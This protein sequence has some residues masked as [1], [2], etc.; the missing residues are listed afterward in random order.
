MHLKKIE[1]K[2]FKSF[3][4]RTAISPVA[5]ITCVVGPNGSGKS[6]I[7]DAVR[8]VLGEQ[9]A[10]IL[11]G[12][13]MEDI[14]FSGTGKRGSLGFAE[15]KL[16]ID[17][18]GGSLKYDFVDIEVS[19]RLYRSGESEYRI[20]G[21]LVRLRDIRDLF[22]DTGVGLEGY[23]I[24]GQGRI[25]EIIGASPMDRRLLFDEASGITAYK[26]KK[27]E[28][29]RQLKSAEGDLREVGIRFEE[30]EKNMNFLAA[31]AL[32]AERYLE[33]SARIRDIRV[34][35][36]SKQYD[37]QKNALLRAE[38]RLGNAEADKQSALDKKNRNDEALGESES[39]LEEL[40][41]SRKNLDRE[42]DELLGN[43]RNIDTEILLNDE[44]IY[45]AEKNLRS[46]NQR[47]KGGADVLDKKARRRDE[48]YSDLEEVG[49]GLAK[50]E[51]IMAKK[52]EEAGESAARLAGLR[53]EIS[54]CA[55]VERENRERADEIRLRQAENSRAFEK[56]EF[57][58]ADEKI[59][60]SRKE[61]LAVREHELREL[62]TGIELLRKT[63]SEIAEKL[64]AVEKSI[65]E[66]DKE[67][68]RTKTELSFHTENID[69][70][71]DYEQS[72]KSIMNRKPEDIY[73]VVG[74]LFVTK[75]KYEEAIETALGRNINVLVCEK[76][77]TAKKYIDELRNTKAGRVSFLP[78][79][80]VSDDRTF[81]PDGAPEGFEGMAVDLIECDPKFSRVFD[82]L[83]GS[84]VVATDF[85]AGRRLLSLGKRV[86]TLRG[87]VFI[88]G[89]I[90][91]G[92]ATNRSGKILSRRRI[93]R[94]CEDALNRL[95]MTIKELESERAALIE[96]RDALKSEALEQE[97]RFARNKL[98][99]ELFKGELERD[100]E[101]MRRNKAKYESEKQR[102]SE[103]S[104]ELCAS[105]EKTAEEIKQAVQRAAA[106]KS[107]SELLEAISGDINSELVN[108]KIEYARLSEQQKAKA[109]E[110]ERISAEIGDYESERREL[111]AE[112][113]KIKDE[114]E[115][116]QQ[117]KSELS[118]K[119]ADLVPEAEGR[120]EALAVLEAEIAEREEKNKG[121]A[122]LSKEFDAEIRRIEDR[123][124]RG[125]TDCIRSESEIR[126]IQSE[127]LTLF[128]MTVE[129]ALEKGEIS[130]SDAPEWTAEEGKAPLT[131][132]T[133]EAELIFL[134][135][136]LAQ[137][138]NVSISSMDEYKIRQRQ[139]EDVG[140]E[141]DDLVK[142]IAATKNLIED[143]S[144]EID[145][146]F[147]QGMDK[148]SASF[149]Y[150]FTRLFGGGEARLRLVGDE[151][152]VLSS[153]VEIAVQ[154]P[155]KKL[156]SISLL[157]GGE[158]ALTAIALLFSFMEQRPS[159]FYI[160]DEI[161]APLDDVNLV[162]FTDFLREYSERA[163]FL[164]IT[165]R[166]STM[167]V[168]DAIFGVTMEE[169]GVSKVI[170]TRLP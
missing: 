66:K 114:I 129:D 106:A 144:R 94:E 77:H 152:D 133:I 13:K 98:E 97:A 70:F 29:E 135:S 124:L 91:T 153:G 134:Q 31:E 61:E 10:K 53:S 81:R 149:S 142:A 4:D 111:S 58:R 156:R 127:L 8:W 116:Y 150:A 73:G 71:G 30:T 6:N 65:S 166:R 88:P 120:I 132:D 44:K 155:G 59:L 37:E 55:D 33:L 117:T 2:G 165:H 99:F 137:F 49:I 140:A 110:F 16:V 76:A 126:R 80:D 41:R 112:I 101:N 122:E 128:E 15:V 85:E 84:I 45:G 69:S 167:E 123:L 169:F 60:N 3:A 1:L 145:S 21:A 32:K 93:A 121:L 38:Q 50:Y 82:V 113:G 62:E 79:E 18:T 146:R 158:K 131:F 74:G 14:I 138:E 68:V 159:P 139:L 96:R 163:Q 161:E 86:V 164:V 103:E 56:I 54:L 125:R 75:K 67:F 95:S 57:E 35:S 11:R 107:E 48:L 115:G 19:R 12:E 20:N 168:A 162:K 36:Y 39:A 151:G 51:S 157:S 47:S 147:R 43:I 154:P 87:E 24:I 130:V 141:R 89:G 63:Q 52:S 170:S 25:D 7:T 72:V 136:T 28:A 26:Q 102:L 40:V 100:L 9:G 83:L 5:G 148:I 27:S 42:R 78:L 22:A 46:L 108:I 90:V 92:G 143:M 160:L 118:A 104:D 17:N 23:S 119:K 109:A 34:S 64:A 105:A